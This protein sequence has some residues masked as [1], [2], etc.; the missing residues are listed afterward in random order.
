MAIAIIEARRKASENRD[1]LRQLEQ[2]RAA[3]VD[4]CT[5][6]EL[7]Q[8]VLR[9]RIH[10]DVLAPFAT[11]FSLVKN[12]HLADFDDFEMPGVRA[13]PVIELIS[14]LEAT[15]RAGRTLLGGAG[16]GATA[17]AGLG[18]ATYAAVGA[19]GVAS[20]GTPIAALA[21]AAAGNATLAFLG[22]GSLAAG[23]GGMAAGATVIGGVVVVP[24]LVVGLGLG[25]VLGRRDLKNDGRNK[26]ELD[27]AAARLVQEE[28]RVDAVLLR[29]EHLREVL[30]RLLDAGLGALGAFTATIED[31]D[32][33]RLWSSADRAR[34]AAMVSVVAVITRLM[35]APLVDGS[36][37]VADL[38]GGALADAHRWLRVYH[39]GGFR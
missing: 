8:D 39:D 5:D 9:A 22:G 34:V 30:H 24:A 21:G 3:L 28:M 10:R 12:V 32:D 33:V 1:R 36:G 20:T 25:T 17:G 4:R 31:L 16:G 29:A 19:F 27:R 7:R 37:A 23:G 26:A 2:Q 14:N 6:E 18:A 15:L 38:D 35:R 11:A 13:M